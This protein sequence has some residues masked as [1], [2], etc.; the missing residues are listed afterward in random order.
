M[1]TT[2]AGTRAE[3][4]Y[5]S[6]SEAIEA[7]NLLRESEQRYRTLF[8]LVP[9]AVYT[10]DTTGVIQNFNRRA[11][12]LWGREPALGDTDE[13]FCGS[14]KLFRPDGTFMPHPECPMALVVTGALSEVRDAEVII[15]RPDGSR[16][17][18]IVNIRPQKN[19]RGDVIGAINCFYDI[20]QRKIGEEALRASEAEAREATRARE[21]MLAVVSHDLRS[22]LSAVA[23][24]VE[25]IAAQDDERI[26]TNVSMMRRC[27][28]RMQRLVSDLLDMASI[29]SRSLALE[30]GVHDVA[31]ILR[32]ARDGWKAKAATKGVE[33]VIT[34][35]D[36][37][38][39]VRCDRDRMVQVLGNLLD[40]AIRFTEAA[41]RIEVAARRTDGMVEFS[42][43]D[44]G[45]G[46]EAEHLAHIFD[47]NWH[48]AQTGRQGHGLGL[49]IAK[50]IVEA[51][52][53]TMTVESAIGRGA[54]FCALLPLTIPLTGPSAS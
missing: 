16:V 49:A 17:T 34:V 1:K 53:G 25:L 29:D 26:A 12:E 36:D 23:H 15:E 30:M 8:D 37:I 27:V 41:G 21:E 54:K 14:Y 33:V 50:G 40:N 38:P 3:T 20:T 39:A 18:V 31:S 9:V 7:F 47:R 46:I 52:G 48:I 43:M 4:E 5:A 11:A 22:P 19:Q 10:I 44:T 2:G 35:E 51:H 28:D 32:D 42:V 45:A 6:S 24:L 13:R